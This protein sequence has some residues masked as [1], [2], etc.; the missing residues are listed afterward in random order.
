MDV[1]QQVCPNGYTCLVN[2]TEAPTPKCVY[3]LLLV[4]G[5]AHARVAR[6]VHN[7]D[8]NFVRVPEKRT[9]NRRLVMKEGLAVGSLENTTKG[10]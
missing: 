7:S 2:F 6:R 1:S 8:L 10:V 3:L 9:M 5:N 4:V